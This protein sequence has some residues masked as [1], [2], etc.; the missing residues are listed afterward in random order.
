[1][2]FF[3]KN[4]CFLEVFFLFRFSLSCKI[5]KLVHLRTI[6]IF[7][8]LQFISISIVEVVSLC[9]QLIKQIHG[10]TADIFK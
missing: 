3:L 10:N 9:Y 6:D 7:Y 2:G 5:K 1:M 4:L 8:F